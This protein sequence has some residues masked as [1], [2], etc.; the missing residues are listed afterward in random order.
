MPCPSLNSISPTPTAKYCDK[1]QQ[2]VILLYETLT[3]LTTAKIAKI[4]QK[5]S[6]YRD[7]HVQQSQTV[8][9]TSKIAPQQ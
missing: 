6:N 1:I 4:L 2:A 8:L 7:R 5:N 9:E 3:A